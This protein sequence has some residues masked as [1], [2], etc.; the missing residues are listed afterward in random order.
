MLRS[1]KHESNGKHAPMGFDEFEE[2]RKD[3]ESLKANVTALGKHL[4]SEGKE[5]AGEARE[6]LD[7]GI[8]T[9]LSKGDKSLEM[10]DD[11]VKD[12]PRRALAMAFA[13]GI[14]LN[15]LMRK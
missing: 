12:N 2:I 11:S 3:L 7:Q 13:A 14:I 9:L 5:K 15:F 10:L 8:D 6:L 1:Q 4:K